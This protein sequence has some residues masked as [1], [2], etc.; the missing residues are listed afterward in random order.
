MQMKS[1]LLIIDGNNML[2]R[3][4]YK[5]QNLRTTKRSPSGIIYGF[6]YILN[7]LIKTHLPD[8]VIVVFDG[9]RDKKRLE[10]HPEYKGSK[11]RKARINFDRDDFF[12]QR[13]EVVKI[14]HY[15]GIKI[16]YQRNKEAD[17]LIWLLA[18]RYKRDNTVVIVSSDKDFAQFISKNVSIWDPKIN[19]RIT[20]KNCFEIKG[21]T[22]EN[23]VDWLT[24]TGDDSD[25]IKGMMGVG[26]GRAKDFFKRG[27][28]IESYLTSDCEEINAF[29]RT[30]LEPVFLINRKLIDVRFFVRKYMSLRDATINIP[31]GINK[32]ELAFICSKHELSTFTSSNFL[33]AFEKLLKNNKNNKLCQKYLS[34][35]PQVSVK[36]L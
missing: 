34:Q 18:R 3:A 33:H 36:Q 26:P 10:L 6:P 5:F 24:L 11:T 28:T 13:N 8:E 29:P 21:Y 31:K 19:Q 22:P 20:H 9:D 4:Y 1:K 15:L 30:L 7:S 25:N 23:C 17:D 14:L 2:Y 27:H 32:K 35:V 12:R 16:L